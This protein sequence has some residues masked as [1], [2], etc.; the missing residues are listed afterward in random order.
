MQKFVDHFKSKIEELCQEVYT[1][2]IATEVYTHSFQTNTQLSIFFKIQTS[3]NSYIF[4]RLDQIQ[5]SYEPIAVQKNKKKKDKMTWFD[6]F[7]E[8]ILND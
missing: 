8:I 7:T 4:F 1:K 6:G 5:N 3:E 2:L